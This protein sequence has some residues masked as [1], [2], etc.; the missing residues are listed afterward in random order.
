M[1]HQLSLMLSYRIG[2]D[3]GGDFGEVEWDCFR[4]I[5]VGIEGRTKIGRWLP[6]HHILKY[7]IDS[8]NNSRARAGSAHFRLEIPFK[9]FRVSFGSKRVSVLEA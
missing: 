8:N 4:V 1:I 3:G 6:D 2:G 5:N 7:D 9:G